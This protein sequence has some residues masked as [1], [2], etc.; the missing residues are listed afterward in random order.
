MPRYDRLNDKQYDFVIPVLRSEV[1][2]NL[3]DEAVVRQMKVPSGLV[4]L[5]MM[6]GCCGT[7]DLG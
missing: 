6:A 5:G 3:R 1:L 7:D 4:G 2:E